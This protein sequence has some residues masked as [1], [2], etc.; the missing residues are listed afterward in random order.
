VIATGSETPGQKQRSG[1]E[2]IRDVNTALS[3]EVVVAARRL[4]SGDILLTFSSDTEKKR[5][6]K[7]PKLTAAFGTNGKLRTRE[8]TILAHGISVASIKVQDQAQAIKDIFTQ[9]PALQGKVE[10]VRVGWSKKTVKYSKKFAPLHIGIKEPEQ[11]NLLLDNGIVLGSEYHD[12]ELFF[13]DC[14]VTQCFNCQAYGH[15]AKHCTNKVKCGFCATV[16]HKTAECSKKEDRT[17]HRCSLC[18]GKHPSWSRDCRA[19]KEQAEAARRAYLSRP[20]RFQVRTTGSPTF[21]TTF[22][23]T[24][25]EFSSQGSERSQGIGEKRRKLDTPSRGRPSA[26]ASLVRASQGTQDIQS[27]FSQASQTPEPMDE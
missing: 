16:G 17:E 13:G 23:S 22:V 21:S 25:I 18:K 6:E 24:P 5:W 12:C 8:H 26:S 4:Q 11:A 20:T 7:D 10:I 14:Q 15:T 9:N 3:Y 19:R 27:L 1:A 2:L